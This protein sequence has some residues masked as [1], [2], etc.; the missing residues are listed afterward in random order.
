MIAKVIEYG[1]AVGLIHSGGSGSTTSQK[2]ARDIMGKNF[3]GV[4]EAIKHFGINP[5]PSSLLPFPKFLSLRRC[6]NNQRILM[7]S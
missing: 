4:E 6:S 5:T 3:F 1:K 2:H 7:F